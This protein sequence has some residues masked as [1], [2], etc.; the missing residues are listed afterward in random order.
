MSVSVNGTSRK[1]VEPV[2][3]S[4]KVAPVRTVE[5]AVTLRVAVMFDPGALEKTSVGGVKMM[6]YAP[7]PARRGVSVSTPLVGTCASVNSKMRYWLVKK[8]AM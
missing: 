5:A 2:A 3:A 7:A 8:L 6:G 1:S 4:S